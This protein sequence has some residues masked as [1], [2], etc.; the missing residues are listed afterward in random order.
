MEAYKTELEKQ[1][2]AKLAE[3][4]KNQENIENQGMIYSFNFKKFFTFK[5]TSLWI[6]YKFKRKNDNNITKR[7]TE[8]IKK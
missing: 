5:L 8:T 6:N 7:N 1:Y 3:K 4:R 2:L